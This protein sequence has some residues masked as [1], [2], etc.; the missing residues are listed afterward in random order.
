MSEPVERARVRR[1]RE[2]LAYGNRF[3]EVFDDEVRFGD[4]T[5]GRYLRIRQRGAGP[6]VVVLPV[7]GDDIGLVRTYRY[8]L[9][10]WQWG[11]PRGLAQDADPL[12]TARAELLEEMGARAAGL[13]L[14]GHMTPDSGL[15]TSRVAV[16]RAEVTAAPEPVRD[17]TEVAETRWLPH[18]RLRE[19]IAKGHLEDG[20]TLAALAL[21]TA[22]DELPTP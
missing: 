22:L 18:T 5:A 8:P 20:M 10:A 2:V 7:R 3:V 11:L 9:G 13:R 12:E 21:A 17:L 14:L 1:S 15:L 19:W 4:G 6:G 16:V